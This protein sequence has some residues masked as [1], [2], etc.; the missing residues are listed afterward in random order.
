MGWESHFKAEAVFKALR[1]K[2]TNTIKTFL[3]IV[4]V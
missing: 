1:D 4:R 2:Y 3:D